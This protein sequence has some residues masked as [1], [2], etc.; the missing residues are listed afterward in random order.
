MIM[1][2]MKN[3]FILFHKSSVNCVRFHPNGSLLASCS[4]DGTIKLFDVRTHTLIQHYAAH[5][6]PAVSID[7]HP[8]G[9][10]LISGSDDNTVKIW[11]LREG[12]QLYTVHGHAGAVLSVAFN[13]TGEQFVSAGC[14]EM[15]MFWNTNFD[16]VVEGVPEAPRVEPAR[17]VDDL[18][19]TGVSN[20]K[21]NLYVP[22]IF[23][24]LTLEKLLHPRLDCDPQLPPLNHSQNQAN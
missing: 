9:D 8:S 19:V 17:S 12:Q 13:N 11:D 15:V 22:T 18:M 14:D 21:S 2:R 7:F 3:V 16:R 6:A 5:M 1:L 23:T 10:F 24:L 20:N 4:S